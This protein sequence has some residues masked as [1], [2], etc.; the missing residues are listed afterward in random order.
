[1][2]DVRGRPFQP[3]NAFG[4]GRPAG[5]RNKATIALQTMLDRH[6]EAILKKA[7]VMALQGDNA[8]IRLCVERLIPV[9]RNSSFKFK[10]PRLNSAADIA[11]A[12]SSVVHAVAAGKLTAADGEMMTGMLGHLRQ[13]FEAVS[14]EARIGALERESKRSRDETPA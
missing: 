2:S 14:F 11:K 4:R 13:V 10:I 1:M 6:A 5:S 8:A 7:V 12:S 3:G 9:R